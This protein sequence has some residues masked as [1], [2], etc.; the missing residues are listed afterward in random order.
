MGWCG[1]RSFVTLATAFAL[2]ASFPQR[3][4]IVLIAFSV[5]LATLVVQGITLA[6]LIRFLKL[7]QDDA[8]ERELTG[9]R[10]TLAQAAFAELG[11]S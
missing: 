1:M 4:L 6:P 7:H 9:A 5:V 8:Q 2:P 11:D 10:V 3:D